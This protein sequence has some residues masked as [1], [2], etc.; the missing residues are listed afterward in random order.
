M[1]LPRPGPPDEAAIMQ[2]QSAKVY[3]VQWIAEEKAVW[4]TECA[5]WPLARA[6]E[7]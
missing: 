6:D 7:R 2:R 1:P 4:K 3:M 5:C